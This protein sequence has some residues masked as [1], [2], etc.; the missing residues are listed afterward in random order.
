MNSS[1]YY[2]FIF[3]L[4]LSLM[5]C[6]RIDLKWNLDKFSL[7]KVEISWDTVSN[8]S[9]KIG[10]KIV[11]DG[12]L[13]I[14]AKGV[15]WRA[16]S[17]PT[18][19]DN[20]TFN[21][22]GAEFFTGNIGGLTINNKYHVRAYATNA[23]GTGY[24]NDLSITTDTVMATLTTTPITSV[25]QRTAVSGGNITNDGGGPVTARGVCWS[26]LTNPTT[27]DKKTTDASGSGSF[28]SYITGLDAGTLYYVRAY[29]TNSAGTAYG[30]QVIFTTTLFAIGQDYGGGKIFYLD[31]AKQH[32]LILSKIE[33]T[34][35]IWGCYGNLLSGCDATTNGSGQA[36]TT[37]IV[38]GCPDPGIAAHICDDLIVDI[39]TDWYLPSK[40]EL[41]LM[42][43][44][45]SVIGGFSS[46]YYWSS[47][48]VSSS[49]AWAQDF[50][51]GNQSNYNKI[52]VGYVRAIRSF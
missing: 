26:T 24:A 31:D 37:S 11:N 39:Y 12:G 25:A 16:D 40:E 1:K 43:Q 8:V 4:L 49:A 42:Y 29:A 34:N 7:P 38:N 5:S 50:S 6:N 18:T 41:N 32:G 17:I 35:K 19:K 30:M 45:K 33:Q 3:L 44:Q 20:K 51:S 2:N 23:L 27:A 52:S 9:A 13:A 46:V 10:G 28:I 14:V 15:C 36:N 21:G 22:A 47:S 48:Q